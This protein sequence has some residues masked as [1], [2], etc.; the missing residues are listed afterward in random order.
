MAIIKRRPE[1]EWD[2]FGFLTDFRSEID[3]VFDRS[4]APWKFVVPSEKFWNPAMDVYQDKDKVVVQ[5]EVPGLSKDDIDVSLEGD[6]LTI[7]GEK[8]EEK[9]EKEKRYHRVERSY[10]YFQRVVEL[11]APVDAKGIKA[12]FKDG[13]LKITL[14]KK[15]EAKPKSIKIDVK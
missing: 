5:A 2:P 7:Q 6:V 15:E 3:R 4:L 8:K 14:P 10:G 12:D 11:P 13:V 9:E 1:G